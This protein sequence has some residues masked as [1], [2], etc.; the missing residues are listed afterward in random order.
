MTI[1]RRKWPAAAAFAIGFSFG[2]VV[3]ECI[4]LLQDAELRT[5]PRPWTWQDQLRSMSDQETD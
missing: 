2:L 1:P 4:I 5:P 3:G